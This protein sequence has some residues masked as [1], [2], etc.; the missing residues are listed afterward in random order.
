VHP[1]HNPVSLA[2]TVPTP[3]DTLRHAALYLQRYGWAHGAP[4][5]TTTSLFPPADAIAAVA[6][7]TDVADVD[8]STHWTADNA[9]NLRDFWAAITLLAD[10]ID[11]NTIAEQDYAHLAC[12]EDNE[13]AANNLWQW[14]EAPA[15]IATNV[16][17]VMRLAADEYDRTHGGAA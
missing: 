6:I 2:P 3:A 9:L 8:W 1:T 7:I 15:Q 16:T 11:G 12:H 4:D 10:Y 5:D 17:D 13:A 14:N